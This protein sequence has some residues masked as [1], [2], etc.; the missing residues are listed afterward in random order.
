[1]TGLDWIVLVATIATIVG[2]GIWRYRGATTMAGYLRGGNELRWPTIG[3]SIM[4][5]QA[6]AITF[7]SMPG[8]AYED[9]MRFVQFYFGLPLAM[10]V[11][12]AVIVPI[13]Y[14]LRV[15]TAYEYLET[16]FD[17]KTRML[18]A[19]LFLLS[20][21]LATGITIYAPAIILS[22]ILGWSLHWTNLGIGV[23]VIAYTV[24]GGTKAVSQTQK[25]QM[26][27]IL[28]GMFVAA[29][30][31]LSRL[32]ESVG[33]HE[34]ASL[35]GALGRMNVVDTAFD[36]SN[37]YNVWSGIVGG[38][39]LAMAYFGTDQSQVQRYLT[40]RSVAESRL[41][42]MFNGMLKIPM[43]FVILFI[44]LLVLTFHLFVQP[45]VFF[46]EPAWEDAKQSAEGPRLEA[47]DA[48]WEEAFEARRGEA[49][50]L[51]TAMES[52]DEAA[53]QAAETRLRE[54]QAAMQGIR[55]EAKEAIVEARPRTETEDTDYIFIGFVIDHLP[56]G[57]VG[58]LVAV[59]LS[60]AMSSTASELNALGSTTVVDFYR[61]GFRQGA[62]DAHYVLASKLFTILWG[63]VAVAFATFAS[64]LDNLIEAVN[65]LGSI[66]YGTVLGVFVVA[67]FIKRVQGSAVFL[68]ALV[69]QATVVTLFFASD[70]GYLWFN[71]V[72]CAV[73][74]FFALLFQ[75]VLPSRQSEA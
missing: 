46:N 36:P 66:F 27:V 50:A 43:Q 35:T 5:T 51:V 16:R 71:L 58:L 15:Y 63:C 10:I 72:G 3:L 1:M 24:L 33:V 64:L 75:A 2:V 68:A 41:G 9:G 52:G 69:G 32:P 22:A 23:V 56:A 11:I 65:I 34:A 29:G 59:I 30:I 25:Q 70:L 53:V 74:V 19:F 7:L 39:F 60:A 17:L 57:L 21:G 13:Y 8:Q 42:L 67:F 26:V 28:T 6:S 62:T 44:G 37:R 14:R 40:G 4:A 31:I 38:F 73:V 45:P 18:G 20:R 61:R 47:I 48:R 49:E 55:A 12:S 54:T